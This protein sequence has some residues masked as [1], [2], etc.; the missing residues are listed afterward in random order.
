MPFCILNILIPIIEE[1]PM[2]KR[3]IEEKIETIINNE[4]YTG[5][6]VITGTR[7]RYQTIHFKNLSKDDATKITRERERIALSRAKIILGE[8]VK[9][10]FNF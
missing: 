2:P 3:V 10:Y 9:E 8:L 6:R 5:T 4:T 1:L 7:I